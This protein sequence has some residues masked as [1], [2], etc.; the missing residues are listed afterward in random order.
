MFFSTLF[1]ELS[2]FPFSFFCFYSTAI[3][4]D[5]GQ[6]EFILTDKTG[7]LTENRM[8][9]KACCIKGVSYGLLTGSISATGCY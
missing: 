2:D 9:F 6:I 4:E 1:M 7:T 8:V 5:L 3:S